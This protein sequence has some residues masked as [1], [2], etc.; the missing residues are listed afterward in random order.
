MDKIPF[1]E[2]LADCLTKSYGKNLAEMNEIQLMAMQEDNRR[3]REC[4]ER[5]KPY[6]SSLQVYRS[7]VSPYPVSK[8]E[9]LREAAKIAVWLDSL[10]PEIYRDDMRRRMNHLR[11]KNKGA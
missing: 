2:N 7:T 3:W 4:E 5:F 9:T 1:A 10:Q 11:E 8:K 6:A